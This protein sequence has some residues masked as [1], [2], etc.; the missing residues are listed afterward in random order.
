MKKSAAFCGTWLGVT[1]FSLFL[2]M[3]PSGAHGNEKIVKL[4]SLEWPP[5]IGAEME[6]QG[7]V[8]EAVRAAFERRGYRVEI[9][10]FPWNRAVAMAHDVKVYGYFPEYYSDEVAKDYILSEKFPGG[11]VGFFKRKD[12]DISFAKLEDLKGYRIGVVKGYV[13]TAEFDAASYLTKDESVDDLMGL[14]KLLAGR[15]DLFFCDKFVGNYIGKKNFPDQI[16]EIEFMDPILEDKPFYICFSRATPDGQR[17]AEDF[18]NGLAE[19]T[20][21]GTLE[22]LRRKGVY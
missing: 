7:Y 13:N 19:I 5:Y 1:I 2:L 3:G 10:F 6:N 15:T 21:D 18:N 20:A 12:K 17:I 4:S 8:A 14:K 9:E 16:A 11:P 22:A